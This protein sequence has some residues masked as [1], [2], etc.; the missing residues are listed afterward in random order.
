MRPPA[1]LLFA[2]VLAVLAAAA[3]PRPTARAAAGPADPSTECLGA[4]AA[5]ERHRQTPPG[6]LATIARVESGRA[7]PPS[8]ALQPWPWTV[9][10]DGQGFYFATKQ[11]AVAWSRRALDSGSV[12]FLDVGC[13][14]IDLRMH[15][16]AFTSLEQAFDPVANA[17]YGARF[18]RELHDGPAGGN[19]FTAV[20]YYHS[21]TE[22]LASAYRAQVIAVAAGRPFRPMPTGHLSMTRLDLVGGAVLR[23]NSNRQPARV[24]KQL[25]PCQIAKILGPTLPRKVAGCAVASR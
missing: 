13:M 21:R 1:R 6:L 25:T 9:D 18:L 20:G 19:W 2:A 3:G 14:Q 24:R 16:T 5:A 15:P 4:I 17:E 7:T 22:L 12:T 10:A 23:I 11:E 8:G